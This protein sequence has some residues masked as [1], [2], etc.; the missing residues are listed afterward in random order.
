MLVYGVLAY[1][2]HSLPVQSV[3]ILLRREADG[4]GMS[5]RAGYVVPD[6]PDGSVEMRYRVVRVWE[7]DP[8]EVLNGPLATLPL[9]PLADVSADELPGIVRRMEGRIETEALPEDRGVLWTTTFLLLG[10]K[11]DPEFSRQR[12]KGVLAMKEPSTYQH[13]LQEGRAE[14]EL[15]EAR[16]ILLRLGTRRLGP[17]DEPTQAALE[18]ITSL[19]RLEQLTDRILEVESWSELLR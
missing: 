14:G 16:K 11:Y 10:L 5:G 3:V 12:L 13:I 8:D 6:S 18:A 15:Q 1:A 4:P 19:E 2:K 17:P 7:K 9:A